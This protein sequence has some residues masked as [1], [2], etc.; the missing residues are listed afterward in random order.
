MP[1]LRAIRASSK[2]LAPSPFRS[3]LLLAVADLRAQGVTGIMR[4]GQRGALHTVRLVAVLS[5]SEERRALDAIVA[6]L[7]AAGFDAWHQ[8]L[9]VVATRATAR[10]A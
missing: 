8:A 1:D 2:P 4:P 5:L 10:A 7:R 3:A 9:E 6:Q